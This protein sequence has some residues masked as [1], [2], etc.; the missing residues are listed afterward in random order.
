MLRGALIGGAAGGVL[1]AAKPLLLGANVTSD[2]NVQ[3][4]LKIAKI[5]RPYL[6]VGQI[7]VRE[8]GLL[9]GLGPHDGITLGN[10]V[11]VDFGLTMD[12]ELL[13]HEF[14]HV[15]QMQA[16]G[17]AISGISTYLGLASQYG[18]QGHPWEVGAR[19]EAS[20]L[21]TIYGP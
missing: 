13:L 4:A 5:E 10:F 7:T 2:P 19:N 11:N 20:Q 1:G 3:Q 21:I 15:A 16:E 9:S 6:D 12:R 8:G 18:Y 14:V 17:G